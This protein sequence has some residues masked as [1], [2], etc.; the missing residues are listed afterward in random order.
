MRIQ[1][2][3]LSKFLPSSNVAQ[4]EQQ[5]EASADLMGDSLT[6][7]HVAARKGNIN[8][9]SSG[10][11]D[12]G[13]GYKASEDGATSDEIEREYNLRASQILAKFNESG[14]QGNLPKVDRLT[15]SIVSGS[16]NDRDD[17][18]EEV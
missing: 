6:T 2:E 8:A 5:Q 12:F 1:Q 18:D 17:D 15:D 7:V 9:A 3:I 11:A 14:R 10:T 16:L 4:G 13:V